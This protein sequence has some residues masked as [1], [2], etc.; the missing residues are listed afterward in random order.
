MEGE[1]PL[2]NKQSCQ[3]LFK[4]PK[5]SWLTVTSSENMYWMGHAESANV[6]GSDPQTRNSSTGRYAA[7]GLMKFLLFLLAAS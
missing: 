3:L 7:G 2:E 5:D 1:R 4:S 6:C